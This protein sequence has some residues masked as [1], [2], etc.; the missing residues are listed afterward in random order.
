M[1]GD[2]HPLTSGSR[3][4]DAVADDEEPQGHVPSSED[5]TGWKP[6]LALVLI[7]GVIPVLALAVAYLVYR[8]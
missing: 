5:W 3:T 4:L 1:I 7:L 2:G 6:V 8:Y